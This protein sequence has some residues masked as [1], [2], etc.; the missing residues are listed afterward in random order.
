MERGVG[1]RRGFSPPTIFHLPSG[2]RCHTLLSPQSSVQLTWSRYPPL[3][4]SFPILAELVSPFSSLRHDTIHTT[5]HPNTTITKL[6][7]PPLICIIMHPF[8]LHF[9]HSGPIIRHITVSA[10]HRISFVSSRFHSARFFHRI[11]SL[12]IHFPVIFILYISPVVDLS[13]PFTTT[14]RSIQL[15]ALH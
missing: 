6:H 15:H 3:D 9:G 12:L 4:H 13:H 7:A 11:R 14:C 1:V 5:I 8:I 10:P 2:Y